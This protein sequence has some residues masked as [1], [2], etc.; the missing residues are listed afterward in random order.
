MKIL[1]IAVVAGAIL[2]LGVCIHAGVWSED[3]EALRQEI[4]E[5]VVP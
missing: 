3:T 4:E 1:I 5:L 2:C